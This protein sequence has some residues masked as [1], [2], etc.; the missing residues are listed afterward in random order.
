M[1]EK[2]LK[3]GMYLTGYSR[4][5]IERMYNDWSK[6]YETANKIYLKPEKIEIIILNFFNINK[7]KTYNRTRIGTVIYIRQLIQYFLFQYTHL[8]KEKIGKRT[9]GF[10]RNT[11]LSSINVIENYITTNK[12]KKI[13]IEKIRKMIEK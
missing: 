1:R 11:V 3:F 6:I 4:E 7:K 9:G 12:E 13:N 2:L 8:S 5:T 10:D